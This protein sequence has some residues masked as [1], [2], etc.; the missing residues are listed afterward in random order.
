MNP[1][2][3]RAACGFSVAELLAA[4]VVLAA[5]TLGVVALYVDRTHEKT[6]TPHAIASALAQDMAERIHARG[7][8]GTAPQLQIA[9]FCTQPP[10]PEEAVPAT[11]NL[12]QDVAC[13]QDSIAR[14]LPNGTGMVE[15]ETARAG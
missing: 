15:R 9:P 11:D 4:I 5:G 1:W 8:V 13:W 10:G 6:R 7:G 3:R 2:L 12:A 14:A